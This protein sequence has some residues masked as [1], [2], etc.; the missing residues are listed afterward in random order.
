MIKKLTLS[1]AC[2]FLALTGQ[3]AE[4]TPETAKLKAK[5]IMNARFA[6]FND[7]EAT[8]TPVMYNGEK[9]YYVVQFAQGWTLSLIHI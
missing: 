3:S 4:V 7:A 5:E 2:L 1:I 6:S 8:V 9:A